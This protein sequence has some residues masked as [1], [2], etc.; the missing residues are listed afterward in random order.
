MVPYSGL[1]VVLEQRASVFAREAVEVYDAD[2]AADGLRDA[3]VVF[4]DSREGLAL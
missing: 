4:A 1:L 3:V 2:V